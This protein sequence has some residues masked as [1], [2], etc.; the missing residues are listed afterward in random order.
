MNIL[1]LLFVSL[2]TTNQPD[3][4]IPLPNL[5]AFTHPKFFY[6]NGCKCGMFNPNF[7]QLEI[8]N[9]PTEIT[10]PYERANSCIIPPSFEVGHSV[11]ITGK[12]GDFFRI[13]FNEEEENP[14]N[15]QCKGCTYYVKK[16]TLGTWVYNYNYG[17]DEFEPVP[18]YKE[19]CKNSKITTMLKGK[20]SVVIILDIQGDWMFVETFTKGKKKSGW[21]DPKMQCGNPYGLDAM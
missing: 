13:K 21:L 15:S 2:L 12:Q 1:S 18:L 11:I 19:P 7:F 10:I 6:N 9:K 5:T 3:S 4:L 8:Y 14:V 20:D 16:G 17:T